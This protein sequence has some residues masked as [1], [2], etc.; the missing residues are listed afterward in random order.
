MIKV[1]G[2][3][4]QRLTDVTTAEGFQISRLNT[5]GTSAL[6]TKGMQ[7]LDAG[8]CVVNID[9]IFELTRNVN[10]LDGIAGQTF[11]LRTAMNMISAFKKLG[12]VL[13]FT[14]EL[15]KRLAQDHIEH[16]RRKVFFDL[17]GLAEEIKLDFECEPVK[18][19]QDLALLVASIFEFVRRKSAAKHKETLTEGWWLGVKVV[20]LSDDGSVRKLWE[21]VTTNL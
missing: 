13:V 4:S 7:N 15:E 17:S 12:L 16:L 20:K 14:D 1:F 6:R 11:F 10:E 9:D 2:P 3:A 19:V 5:V 21:D 8:L 18:R